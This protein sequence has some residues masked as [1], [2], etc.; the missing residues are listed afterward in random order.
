MFLSFRK[1]SFEPVQGA[2]GSLGEDAANIDHRPSRVLCSAL[3][4]HLLSMLQTTQPTTC[5]TEVPKQ[6]LCNCIH[7]VQPKI[8]LAGV[9]TYLQQHNTSAGNAVMSCIACSLGKSNSKTS[10]HTNGNTDLVV[11]DG[12]TLLV[13]PCLPI[14]KIL[15]TNTSRVR[16]CMVDCGYHGIL[17]L[18]KGSTLA[19]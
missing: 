16:L 19:R 8:V 14:P 3:Q 5:A 9:C 7:F 6:R 4:T 13:M 18:S 12:S 2:H 10:I 15:S 17:S 11:L 1:A